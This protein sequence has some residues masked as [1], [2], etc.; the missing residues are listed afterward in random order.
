MQFCMTGSMVALIRLACITYADTDT[1]F[2]DS[3]VMMTESYAILLYGVDK[4]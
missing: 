4:R 2:L 3:S 1:I